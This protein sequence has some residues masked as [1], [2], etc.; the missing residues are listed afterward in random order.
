MDQLR[1]MTHG[2]VAGH[3]LLWLALGM[4]IL[5]AQTESVHALVLIL[6]DLLTALLLP[7]SR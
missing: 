7:A 6:R 4:A 1:Y 3:P 5:L 2:V